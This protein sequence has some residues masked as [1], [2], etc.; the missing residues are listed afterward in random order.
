M[1]TELA[2]SGKLSTTTYCYSCAIKKPYRSKH[3]GLCGKCVARFDHHCPFVDNCVG[4]NNH[5]FFMLFLI[6]LP[7]L[8]ITYD[9]LAFRC[10]ST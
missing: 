3:C 8:I 6:F 7:W 2:E 4:Q 9:V 5:R 10:K 1:I